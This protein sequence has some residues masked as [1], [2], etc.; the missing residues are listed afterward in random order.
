M[1]AVENYITCSEGHALAVGTR[2]LKLSLCV[3][4][5]PTEYYAWGARLIVMSFHSVRLIPFSSVNQMIT[6]NTMTRGDMDLIV[7]LFFRISASMMV[8]FLTAI[9]AIHYGL[10]SFQGIGLVT[11]AVF[12]LV[13]YGQTF[14]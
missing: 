14:K 7:T 12:L 1:N 6:V 3:S 10:S 11:F 9:A 4:G 13:G 8:G 2:L 5:T